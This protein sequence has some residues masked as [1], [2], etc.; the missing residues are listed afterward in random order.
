[1]SDVPPQQQQEPPAQAS[2]SA[3]AVDGEAG[4]AAA[5][6]PNTKAFWVTPLCDYTV[7]KACLCNAEVTH[8]KT[9]FLCRGCGAHYCGKECQ[10]IDYAARHKNLC[11]ILALTHAIEAYS[12][13]GFVASLLYRE[14]EETGDAVKRT[15][16]PLDHQTAT[17][18]SRVL[19]RRLSVL[20][21]SA[22][23][24][25]AHMAAADV[26]FDIDDHVARVIEH[27]LA[28][29]ADKYKEDE[30]QYGVRASSHGDSIALFIATA[31]AHAVYASHETSAQLILLF[32]FAFMHL[33]RPRQATRNEPQPFPHFALLTLHVDT[34][35]AP[36]K[37]SMWMEFGENCSPRALWALL[38]KR[39][40]F[41]TALVI[42]LIPSPDAH[43]N[44]SARIHALLLW[45]SKTHAI[46]MQSVFERYTVGDWIGR[47]V[48]NNKQPCAAIDR[49][50]PWAAESLA[51]AKVPDLL[52]NDL[53]T[54][55]SRD[56][57]ARYY[58]R[59]ATYRRICALAE[60]QPLPGDYDKSGRFPAEFQVLTLPV[61]LDV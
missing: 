15:V 43:G 51:R 14:E 22:V 55:V 39:S 2:S 32:S 13:N 57:D 29:D 23:R 42:Y 27:G 21:Y 31:L 60:D 56:G 34:P 26:R 44:N 38:E 19:G 50:S 11:K 10:K 53:D 33:S 18:S 41:N 1:M 35:I 3:S 47:Y 25:A 8:E 45:S 5:P 20:A 52:F 37:R 48:T 28:P 12:P 24:M 61:F 30:R 58:N 36:A 59:Q 7:M 46:V 17:S 40:Q 54:L 9:T 4:A 6:H 49:T 16:S